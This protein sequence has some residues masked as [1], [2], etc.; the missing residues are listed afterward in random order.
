MKEKPVI[1]KKK[2]D[3]EARFNRIRWLSV[4]GGFMDGV[5]IEFAQGLNCIIGAR[6]TGKTTVGRR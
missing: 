3:V 1:I 6:G 4:V 2:A 5:D